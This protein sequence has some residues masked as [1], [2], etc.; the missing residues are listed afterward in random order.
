MEYE[1]RKVQPGSRDREVT[2]ED[3]DKKERKDKKVDIYLFFLS[4]NNL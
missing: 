3:L 1:D 2:A 4:K